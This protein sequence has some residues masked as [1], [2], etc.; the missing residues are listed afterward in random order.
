MVPIFPLKEI[1][2]VL[3]EQIGDAAIAVPPTEG[4]LTTTVSNIDIA[5]EQAPL[6]TIAR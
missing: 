4:A 3:P 6:V 2:V 5:E 1:V